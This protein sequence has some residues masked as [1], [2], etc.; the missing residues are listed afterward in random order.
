M[1]P[2]KQYNYFSFIF[3]YLIIFQSVKLEVVAAE[4]RGR[5]I[6]GKCC[7]RRTDITYVVGTYGKCAGMCEERPVC[8]AYSYHRLSWICRLHTQE[9]PL[10]TC[11]GFLHSKKENWTMA[12]FET[13]PCQD[14]QVCVKEGGSPDFACD[15]RECGPPSEPINGRVLGNDYRVGRHIRYL[16]DVGFVMEGNQVSECLGN[17]QWSVE[18]PICKTVCP[19]IGS[20]EWGLSCYFIVTTLTKNFIDASAYCANNGGHVIHVTSQEEHDFITSNLLTPPMNAAVERYWVGV[21]RNTTDGLWYLSDSS[22]AVVYMAWAAYE[23]TNGSNCATY[24]FDTTASAW[25]WFSESCTD[26]TRYP[27]CEYEK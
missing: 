17:G 8:T 27:I 26:I 12:Y 18:E 4:T 11:V 1:N 6:F 13:C 2:L 9:C 25:K 22:K 21:V 24:K 10:E 20:L 23:P 3:I 16:C 19:V 15:I 5:V 7:E 14:G